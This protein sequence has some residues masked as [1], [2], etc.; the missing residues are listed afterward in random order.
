MRLLYYHVPTRLTQ[1]TQN[2]K[3]VS[4]RAQNAAKRPP[5]HP[6]DLRRALQRPRSLPSLQRPT[7]PQAQARPP[8]TTTPGAPQSSAA[9]ALTD[10]ELDNL[11]G[12]VDVEAVIAES[13]RTSKRP[14]EGKENVVNVGRS[15]NVGQ[16]T[17]ANKKK[18]GKG[19]HATPPKTGIGGIDHAMLDNL[20]EGLDSSDF[21]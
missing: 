17:D 9:S 8:H 21:A 4:C 20:L 1:P 15:A 14:V 13:M 12:S 5:Q 2:N 7:A 11:F 19:N 16:Q 3:S 10:D 6:P 18:E